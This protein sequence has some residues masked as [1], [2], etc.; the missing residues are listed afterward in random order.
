[1]VTSALALPHA[2]R[3]R[4]LRLKHVIP[5]LFVLP[6]LVIF[7]VF[8]FGP[9]LYSFWISLTD[10]DGLGVPQFVG[11]ANYQRLLTEPIFLAALRNSFF[12]TIG[13]MAPMMVLALGLALMLNSPLQG[14]TFFR[15]VIYIPV[16]ISWVAGALIWQLIFLHPNGFMNAFL[17]FFG[18][19]AQVWTNNPNL[20]LPAI[21]W[22]SI[23]K[24][25]GFYMVIFLAGLQTIPP[26]MYEAAAIDGA[27]KWNQFW[28]ITLPLLRPTTLFVLVIGII[29]S[30]EVFI[31]I[32]LLTG[33][34]PG[35]SS[36]VMVMAIYRFGFETYETGYAS[37]IAV[38]LFLIILVASIVQLRL[39]GR[40]VTY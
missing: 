17:G 18:I 20:V 37:A 15:T 25:L 24:G 38:V 1:M 14:R 8:L 4:R 32:F 10:W 40:E 5:Y 31:P 12:Y 2:K 36:M 30:F 11:L 9:T 23:W 27:S 28:N 13:T 39:F 6:N 7:A 22:M 21:I 35:Y 3:R 33:G 16:V 34:G 26:T 29:G 19:P